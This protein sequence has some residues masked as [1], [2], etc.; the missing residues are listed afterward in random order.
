MKI[1]PGELRTKVAYEAKV[2]VGRDL[3]G[4]EVRDWSTVWE[5]FAAVRALSAKEVY[6]AGGNAAEGLHRVTI[7]WR[8]DV[9]H[10]GR[11]R[12]LGTSPPQYLYVTGVVNVERRNAW[13][14]V[15][16]TSKPR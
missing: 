8:P 3:D 9:E 4:Q 16:A 7:R 14:V 6:Y 15:A 2:V 1:D 10:S 5:G 12:L 13:L 11:F